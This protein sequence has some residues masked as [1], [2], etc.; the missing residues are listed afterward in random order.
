MASAEKTKDQPGVIERLA[1]WNA[2]KGLWIVGGLAVAAVIFPAASL[3][4][5]AAGAGAETLASKFVADRAKQ[6]RLR[7]Q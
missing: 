5:L 7:R 4:D 6:R 3:L 2:G 1:R